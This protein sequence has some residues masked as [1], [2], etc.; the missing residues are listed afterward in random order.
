VVKHVDAAEVRIVVAVVLAAAA[1][2]AHLGGGA[3][4]WPWRW[5]SR[6][7]CIGLLRRPARETTNSDKNA[8]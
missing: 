5:F 6:R 3:N 8:F 1:D 7:R 2:A 4:R